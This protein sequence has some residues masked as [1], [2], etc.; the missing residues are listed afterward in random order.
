M[1][2][3]V[4]L[5]M[6]TRMWYAMWDAETDDDAAFERRVD[7]VVRE[8]GERGKVLVPESVPPLS[9]SASAQPV[10]P[11][12]A[13]A[14]A[15]AVAPAP[16]A[17]A[18]APA[19]ALGPAASKSLAKA[20]ATSRAVSPSSSVTPTL[21]LQQGSSEPIPPS[22]PASV[23][24]NQLSGDVSL[25]ATPGTGTNLMEVSAFMTEQ[26]R[27][28]MTEQ[29]AH[30]NAQQAKLETWRQELEGK[31]EKQR[32]EMEAKLER[33]RAEIEAQ[34]Q[35]Y[36]AKLEAQRQEMEAKLEKQREGCLATLEAHRLDAK[37][38][39]SDA[40][41]DSVQERLDSLHQAKLLSDDE[42]FSLEDTL[43]HFIK[44]RSSVTVAPGETGAAADRVR[45]LVG[46]CEGVSKDGMF[47]RQLRRNFL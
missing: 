39:V 4:G 34:R 17:P 16:A 1:L 33:Q 29:R 44:C 7:G 12:P 31:L 18:P 6:G 24:P 46:M 23:G 13:P 40:Q 11:A 43:A 20:P 36:E 35:E 37:N 3:V 41:L 9:E 5:I 27:A 42:M 45:Q 30:D 8:V 21:V 22:V 25:N 2:L 19:Q 47:A 38:Y 10:V 32:A 26:L 15:P 28:Q 14:P